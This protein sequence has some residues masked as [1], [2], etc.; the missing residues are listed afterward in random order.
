[1]SNLTWLLILWW[2]Q[3]QHGLHFFNC[4]G[5][6]KTQT[7]NL[8]NTKYFMLN[9]IITAMCTT[10]PNH[11]KVIHQQPAMLVVLRLHS[12]SAQCR[13]AITYIYTTE[14][15]HQISVNTDR[16]PELRKPLVQFTSS[17]C[18]S[19]LLSFNILYHISA[20]VFMSSDSQWASRWDFMSSALS[21]L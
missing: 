18:S 19:Y 9:N 14:D 16:L 7:W 6:F 21:H 8:W 17:H 1:M 2:L 13:A 11:T 12:V 4:A 15:H 20:N 5:G 10:G 3:Q